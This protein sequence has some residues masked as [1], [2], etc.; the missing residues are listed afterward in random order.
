MVLWILAAALAVATVMV[1]LRP[2]WSARYA[3]P[4][5]A[6]HDV[7]AYKNQLDE[8]TRDLER[9]MVS[10]AEAEGA[11]REISRRLLA[12]ADAVE[13]EDDIAPAAPGTARAVMIACAGLIAVG[14]FVLYD[15]LGLFT[16]LG[17]PQLPAQP[18]AARDF[19]AERF[20]SR[21]DQAEAERL[22]EENPP[23]DWAPPEPP[24]AQPG[25]PDFETLLVRMEEAMQER[26]DD[27]QGR[28]ILARAYLRVGR[29]AEAWPLLARAIDLMGAA[30]P[31]ELYAEQGQAMS[32]AA[33]GYV[34][35]EAQE[36]FEAAS[37]LPIS[38]Y[39]LG[40]ADA[41]DGKFR[42]ALN[43]WVRLIQEF[44]NAPFAPLLRQQIEEMAGEAGLAVRP[45]VLPPV[46][47]DAP[48][49]AA[50]TVPSAPGPTSEDIA[51][52][53]EM[54][55]EDRMAMIEGMVEGLAERL[56]EQPNDLEGWTRL[57]QA[58]SVLNRGEDAAQALAD[59]RAAFAE[60]EAAL[61]RLAAAAR[62]AGL[63]AE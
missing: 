28:L 54:T 18:L 31:L 47:G 52:A 24:A 50:P 21:L 15:G 40:L 51:A 16:G 12:A 39:F 55:A 57:I 11:K 46:E 20:A 10:P 41:Q 36:V 49:A 63:E 59:A 53:Q 13:Q 6:A 27:V 29:A 3:A 14:S 30:A 34:S 48:S 2:L 42:T 22:F 44:P 61:Q 33:G 60:D 4:S 35:R 1:A 19:D 8:V 17:A 58:F 5:R 43:G 62:A 32:M 45:G 56:E 26:P 23:E 7:A 37:S 25:Q 9:G 38:R